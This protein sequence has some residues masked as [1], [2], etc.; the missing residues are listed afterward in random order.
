MDIA[1]SSNSE[2]WLCYSSPEVFDLLLQQ[3]SGLND[4][5]ASDA[6]S[7]TQI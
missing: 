6:S 1:R 5:S 2:T 4:S 3:M 7:N